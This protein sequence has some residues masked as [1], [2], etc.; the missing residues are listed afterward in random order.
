MFTVN[1]VDYTSKKTY[2][3]IYNK[4]CFSWLD[5]KKYA[6]FVP[7]HYLICFCFDWLPT[8][9]QYLTN[10]DQGASCDQNLARV[11]KQ[12]WTLTYCTCI[13]TSIL[14]V[15]FF[16]SENHHF[17]SFKLR[18]SLKPDISNQKLISNP[19]TLN[20]LTI[21]SPWWLFP[22]LQRCGWIELPSSLELL[23]KDFG[24]PF[25]LQQKTSKRKETNTLPKF[26]SEFTPKHDG[27]GRGNSLK[28]HGGFWCPC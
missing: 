3:Y 20:R 8:N 23:S 19:P 4:Y 2:I 13:P 21:S 27:L 7:S 14:Y 26:N 11:K 17:L 1:W 15:F 28:T 9:S 25:D 24:G 5:N 10:L 22:H 12:W 16:F 6:W 18:L